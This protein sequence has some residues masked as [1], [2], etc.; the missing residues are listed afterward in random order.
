MGPTRR[1]DS[2]G[3][4]RQ[5]SCPE[6]WMMLVKGGSVLFGHRGERFTMDCCRGQSRNSRLTTM[7]LGM[8]SGAVKFDNSRFPSDSPLRTPFFALRKNM[9]SCIHGSS[10]SKAMSKRGHLDFLGSIRHLGKTTRQHPTINTNLPSSARGI[11]SGG[12]Y[13]SFGDKRGEI[14]TDTPQ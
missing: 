11:K 1:G 9:R 8:E 13:S 12:F 3:I 5:L 10:E 6:C 2:M 4:L 14:K 7:A